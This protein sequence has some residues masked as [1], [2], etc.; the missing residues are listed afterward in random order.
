MGNEPVKNRAAPVLP[1]LPSAAT[2]SPRRP[3]R[4]ANASS[5]PRTSGAPGAVAGA[6]CELGDD[7]GFGERVHLTACVAG[8]Y[9]QFALEE[10][11]VDHWTFQQQVRDPVNGGVAA[12]D[13]F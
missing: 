7:P 5:A 9:A 10:L 1:K 13:E 4:S 12:G 3:A 8:R 6:V 11:R 2:A